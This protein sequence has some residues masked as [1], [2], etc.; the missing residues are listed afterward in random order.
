MCRQQSVPMR[1]P[2]VARM[3]CPEHSHLGR[4]WLWPCPR[5]VACPSPRGGK[6]HGRQAGRDYCRVRDYFQPIPETRP[7]LGQALDPGDQILPQ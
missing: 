1:G 3:V 2:R 4:L 7:L 5:P 6:A